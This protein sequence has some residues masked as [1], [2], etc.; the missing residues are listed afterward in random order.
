MEENEAIALANFNLTQSQADLAI[1]VATLE[2]LRS[3]VAGYTAVLT[4]VQD[5][6][7]EYKK[8]QLLNLATM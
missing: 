1:Y 7:V 5:V 6:W 8:S 4:A 2:A 3:A